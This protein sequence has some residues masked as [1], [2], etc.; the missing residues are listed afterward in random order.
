METLVVN[1]LRWES[2]SSHFSVSEALDL[3]H[4][5]MPREAYLTHASHRI[6]LHSEVEHRLPAGVKMAYDGLEIDIN[7]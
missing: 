4:R 5:V 3:I 6:G 7:E 2:H 1:A